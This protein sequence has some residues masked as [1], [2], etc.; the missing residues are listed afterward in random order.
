M[1]E[2]SNAASLRTQAG[3]LRLTQ[4]IAPSLVLVGTIY[5]G[6]Q[7]NAF[8]GPAE[9]PVT[10][11]LSAAMIMGVFMFP[12]GAL[13]IA[14]GLVYW[15]RARQA[16]FWPAVTGHIAEERR[17]LPSYWVPYWYVVNGIR[18][19]KKLVRSGGTPTG[20]DKD[21]AVHFDP[22]DPNIGV[23]LVSDATARLNIGLGFL[24]LAVP[25]PLAWLLAWLLAGP[26]G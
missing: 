1:V 10:S 19:D 14:R 15:S 3:F 21:I 17:A 5:A 6:A 7:L 11:P 26:G 23:V 12:G 16:R 8:V 9:M 20:K 22:E 18:Y 13:F 24:A 2:G 4:A 25:F